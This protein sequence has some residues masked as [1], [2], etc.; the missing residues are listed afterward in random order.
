MDQRALQ[1]FLVLAETLHFGRA[2]ATCHV[3]PS[4]LSR[5]I[6]KLEETLGAALFLRDNRQVALTRE[7]QIFRRYAEDAVRLWADLEQDLL[8]TSGELRGRLTVYSSVTASYSFLHDLL[9][10]LRQAHPNI[11]ISLQT[12]DPEQ[13]IPSVQSGEVQ[14][15]IGALPGRLPNALSFKAVAETPLVFIAATSSRY[16]AGLADDA[17]NKDWQQA[18]MILPERGVARENAL[19]WFRRR[20]ISPQIVSEVAGNEAIVSM[21]SLGEAIGLVPR[22]VLENSPLAERVMTIAVNPAP[23]PLKVGLFVQSRNLSN[24][25]VKALW[26]IA[27]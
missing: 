8:D 13:A 9:A 17:T 1:Q 14:I 25:L 16:G 21:V 11:D 27:G 2:A 18:P 24:R 23:A 7:G 15:S 20:K 5:A 6:L 19:A 12:G 22:I 4:T 3:S 26:D 10:A